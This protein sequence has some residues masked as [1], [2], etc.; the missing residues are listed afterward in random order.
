MRLYIIDKEKNLQYTI[1][2]LKEREKRS[3]IY[4][5]VSLLFTNHQHHHRMNHPVYVIHYHKIFIHAK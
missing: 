1:M 3:T 2:F 5:F 4:I